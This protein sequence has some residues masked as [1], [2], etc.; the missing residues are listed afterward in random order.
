VL[1]YTE[2]ARWPNGEGMVIH[3]TC[4]DP[5]CPQPQRV[6]AVRGLL[7]RLVD[8]GGVPLRRVTIIPKFYG[9]L[10]GMQAKSLAVGAGIAV[11]FRF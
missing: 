9:G 6:S 11:G 1:L 3:A 10:P 4:V 8:A 7:T 2:P 5:A